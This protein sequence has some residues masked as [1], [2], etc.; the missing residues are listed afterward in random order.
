MEPQGSKT[1]QQQN[2]KQPGQEKIAKS[3]VIFYLWGLFFERL[4]CILV[5]FWSRLRPSG[6]FMV[7]FWSPWGPFG[8]TFGDVAVPL[9]KQAPDYSKRISRKSIFHDFGCFLGAL[10]GRF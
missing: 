3:C 6:C 7:K 5:N 1:E 8:V 4:G 9:A 2:Q 10:W